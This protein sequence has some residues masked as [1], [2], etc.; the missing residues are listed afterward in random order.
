V[1][2]ASAANPSSDF[3]LFNGSYAALAQVK[4]QPIKPVHLGF[5]YVRAFYNAQGRVSVAA[6]TGTRFANMA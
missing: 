6:D 2:S 5:T 4:F 3:G 1:P